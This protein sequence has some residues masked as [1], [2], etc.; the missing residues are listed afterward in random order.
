[1]SEINKM[2]ENLSANSIERGSNFKP[3]FFRIYDNTN[4]FE[5]N[6]LLS[7]P[8]ITVFDFIYD[9]LKELIKVKNPSVKFN[10]S[11]LSAEIL[12]HIA[13]HTLVTYG[14]WV[15]YPWSNRLV[16]ILDE[17]EFIEVRTSRNQYKITK[18]ERNHLSTKKIGVIGLSV[19]QSVSV[20]LAMERIC[21]ELRLADFD[22]LELT[23]LNRIRTGVHNLGLL[24]VY[25]VAREIAEIDPFLNV[26]CFADG[27][28]ENNI[29]A[30]FTEG[31][32]LDLLIEESD[33]F[34]IKILSRYKARSLKIPVLMEASDRCMVDVE[35][36]DLEP[37]RPILHGLVNHLD[38]NTLKNL[39]TTE[40]K[41]PY[42]LDILGLDTSSVRLKASMIEIEQSINTWPQL[43]SAVTMGGGIAA[44]VSR[45]LLLNQYT[46]SGR[47]HVDIEELIGNKKNI[48]I[49]EKS[50]VDYSDG[51]VDFIS[52]AKAV[53]INAKNGQVKISKEHLEKIVEAGCK[54][55][56]GG[57]SQPWRWVYKNDNLLL[58]NA[59]DG[60]ATFL[61]FGNFASY[62][63]FGAATEN[64][65]LQAA[66]LGYETIVNEFPVE[67]KNLIASFHFIEKSNKEFA[68]KELINGIN[69]RITNRNLGARVPIANEI[70]DY[71][72]SIASQ[73]QTV[74]LDFF[75]DENQLEA[76]GEIISELEKIR[77]LEEQGHKDFVNEIRWTIEEAESKKDG[78]DLRTLQLTNTEK[79]GLEV[80][81]SNEVIKLVNDWNGGGAFKK[82]TK[83][84]IDAAG[85]IGVLSSADN[86]ALG[87][88]NGGR[89]MQ[90]VWIAANLKGVA[91]QPVAASVF[92][93]ARLLQG[94]GI[95]ISKPGC[96]K[97]KVLRTAYE[98]TFDLSA[99]KKELFI[100][101]L[102]KAAMPET[103]ALRKPL[104]E[105]F[106]TIEE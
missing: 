21:G 79:V 42:M 52:L 16:H 30:F 56:S 20:T 22:V 24:K 81:K 54:A 69:F 82:L 85:A 45:R 25:A 97:L 68:N 14:V 86:S 100:F 73:T 99:T 70:L 95:N 5:F 62:V 101:R 4:L 33:G 47:Y 90:R 19:G 6:K 34:D 13:P 50:V 57:N 66:Q 10:D 59:F 7:Q 44:D 48:A 74:K 102:S 12:K 89:A 76:I 49:I 46:Q 104:S 64:V 18:E 1:M 55:P 51:L 35:R 17:A 63:A 94:N 75:T 43:A 36:F 87:F 77:L 103:L 28:T 65:I 80:A 39:K 58:I 88:Y 40:E 72:K 8:G 32:N 29:D 15:F 78:V 26:K 41:I 38:M 92:V 37:K 61:G 3:L 11:E 91:F 53:N 84:S 98:T 93:Y 27:V 23:N 96:E 60:N 2:L 83:K 9:Q 31:G 71:F 105:M 106:Y 67:N